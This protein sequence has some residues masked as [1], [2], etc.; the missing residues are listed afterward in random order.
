MSGETLQEYALDLMTKMN[1]IVEKQ[2]NLRH[3]K[4]ETIKQKFAEGVL[5]LNLRRELHW[6]NEKRSSLMFWELR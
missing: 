1:V 2:S 6:L 4:E 5:D 3:G